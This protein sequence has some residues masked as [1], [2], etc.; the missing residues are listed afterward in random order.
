MAMVRLPDGAL[1]RFPADFSHDQIQNA[2]EKLI[3][4]RSLS[5]KIVD[6]AVGIKKAFTGEEA[7]TPELESLEEAAFPP[8]VDMDLADK[9][10]LGWGLLASATP[11]QRIDI[12]GESVPDAL[13]ETN[14]DGITT[15]SYEGQKTVLNRPGFSEADFRQGLAE[16]LAFLPI[17]KFGRYLKAGYGSIGASRGVQRGAQIVGTGLGGA[18][19]SVALDKVAEQAGSKQGVD[20]T[21]AA[22]SGGIEAA[23]PA[24]GAAWDVGK[25]WWQK[26]TRPV[27][28]DVT[29]E[30]AEQIAKAKETTEATGIELFSAQQTGLATQLKRQMDIA[31]LPASVQIA[32]KALKK[33]NK[34]AWDATQAVINTVAEPMAMATGARRFR[35]AAENALQQAK[36]IREE[37]ASPIYKLAFRRQRQSKVPLI[38]TSGIVERIRGGAIKK[39]GKIKKT[40]LNTADE[41]ERAGG[42]LE[43][44]HNVKLATDDIL[45]KITGAKTLGRQEKR[46]LAMVQKEFVDSLKEASPTYKAAV[47][48]HIRLSPGVDR[49]ENSVIKTVTKIK[50]GKLKTTSGLI[51]DSTESNPETVTLVREVIDK[52]DP[53]AYDELLRVELG[54]RIG[55][56]KFSSQASEVGLENAPGDLHRAL[57]GNTAR[58]DVLFRALR[59]E[60][61]PQARLLERSLRLASQG[62]KGAVQVADETSLKEEL[63]SGAFRKAINVIGSPLQELGRWGE[64]GAIERNAAALAEVIYNPQYTDDVEAII[65]T[66]RKD[67]AQAQ[68][69][70]DKLVIG[71]MKSDLLPAAAV[72]GAREETG[73][74]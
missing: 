7:M 9:M 59:P 43:I 21:R 57:F 25:G 53:G 63:K 50:D 30:T 74:D 61:V 1:V 58:T 3:P 29:Q 34:Q 31:R 37:A 28:I 2:M 36:D 68:D 70:F 24:T 26:A 6:T 69:M 19:V 71:I 49:I 17:A 72:V 5:K 47:A 11:Q 45:S 32:A 41:I 44:L 13:I 56:A 60:Q 20:L 14:K 65:R 66:L 23:F 8:N 46:E 52:I 40:L 12:I 48:E 39:V 10:K 62:R 73:E 33:Q 4:E 55:R 16:A 18:G 15:I 38:D 27:P 35:S 64:K 51:F 22:V 67:E 54:R 42:D